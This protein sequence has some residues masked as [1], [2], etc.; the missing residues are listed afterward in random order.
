VLTSFAG[1]ID[2][3]TTLGFL[4]APVYAILNHRAM[5]SADVA[6][7]YAPTKLLR[8]W[9]IFSIF[10]LAIVSL[11]FVYFKWTGVG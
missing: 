2:I 1:F 6:P 9:S 11:I 8:R 5:S 3:A 10:V 4:T 7:E